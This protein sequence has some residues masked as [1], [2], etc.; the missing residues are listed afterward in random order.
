MGGRSRINAGSVV[1]GMLATF[2]GLGV[3]LGLAGAG[4][5][6]AFTSGWWGVGVLAV[7]VGLFAAVL[8]YRLQR[9]RARP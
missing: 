2:F 4:F 1:T 7:L 3:A 8:T 9:G 5:I 6:V